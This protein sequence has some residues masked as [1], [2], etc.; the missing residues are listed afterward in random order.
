MRHIFFI[1]T[2]ASSFEVSSEAKET[3]VSVVTKLR[4]YGEYYERRISNPF[5][6]KCRL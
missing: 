5:P 1:R 4:R 2:A 3:A 6:R